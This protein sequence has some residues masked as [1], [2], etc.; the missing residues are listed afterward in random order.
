VRSKTVCWYR[1]SAVYRSTV[2]TSGPSR[3]TFA[4]PAEGVVRLI[5]RTAVPEKVSDT[6]PGLFRYPLEPPLSLRELRPDQVPA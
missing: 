4:V 1:V 5:H 3:Y 6:E 2:V